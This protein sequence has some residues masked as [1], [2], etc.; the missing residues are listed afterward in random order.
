LKRILYLRHN[1][2]SLRG[3]FNRV[4]VWLHLQ[5][6]IQNGRF[7]NALLGQ[8]VSLTC[9]LVLEDNLKLFDV[10]IVARFAHKLLNFVIDNLHPVALMNLKFVSL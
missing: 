10:G 7:Y 9:D 8:G 3:N 5:K 4:R 1:R 6:N 2:I